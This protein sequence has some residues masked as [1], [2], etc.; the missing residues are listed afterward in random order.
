M[1]HYYSKEQNDVESNPSTYNFNFK[2]LELKFRTDN[3][4]FS[5]NYINSLS[6]TNEP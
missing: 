5:K 6:I 4:V 2:G 3:G 1:S